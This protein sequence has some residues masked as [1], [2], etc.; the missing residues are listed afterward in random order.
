MKL[1]Q[2]LKEMRF[3]KC[4]KEPSVYHNDEGGDF[5]LIAIYVDDL[6]LSVTLRKVI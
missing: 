3:K 5:L 2:V 4:T 1:D 6:F